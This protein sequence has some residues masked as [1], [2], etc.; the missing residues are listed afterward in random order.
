MADY[1]KMW[2]EVLSI[3]EKNVTEKTYTETISPAKKVHSFE[4]NCFNIVVP[5]AFNKSRLEKFFYETI[6]E[7]ISEHLKNPYDVKFILAEEIH[8]DISPK[9]VESKPYRRA[10]KKVYSFNNYVVGN[11][12]RFAYTTSLKVAE[13]P[14]IVANPLYIFG[15]VGLGKTH[16]MH[17]IGNYILD[18]SKDAKVLYIKTEK[19][20]EKFVNSIRNKDKSLFSDSFKDID[21]LLI[22][23]IQF[24]SKGEESQLEFFKIFEELHNKNKQIVVTSDRKPNELKNMMDRLTSRFE[25][26]VLVDI[27]VP[28]YENRIEIVKKK[29]QAE[30]I[31]FK[32]VNED[33]IKYIAKIFSNN[34][35]ELESALRRVLFYS[36][37]LNEECTLKLAKESLKSILP[38]KDIK[39]VNYK[40]ILE[41]VSSYY[42]ISTDDILSKSRK[43]YLITPRYISMYLMSELLSLTLKEIGSIFNRDHTSVM[44]GI[45]TIKLDLKVDKDLQKAIETLKVF[46]FNS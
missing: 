1:Q 40:D 3:I 19:F 6:L 38:E 23:D 2:D 22:D 9:E 45:K 21:I 33:V 14:G 35:R 16:L 44:H 28:D 39:A 5:S 8:N 15:G 37:M 25:W 31:D 7:V 11:F 24:L 46:D 13:Q 27:S 41:N 36:T 4:E 29:I 17:A 26:G 34:V 10:V 30:K 32:S 20:I 42:K 12:N 43:K 18:S